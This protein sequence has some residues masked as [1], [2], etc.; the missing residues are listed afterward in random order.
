MEK[1]GFHPT[2]EVFQE[3]VYET[4]EDKFNK[5]FLPE[6]SW[7][8]ASSSFLLTWIHEYHALVL[9]QVAALLLVERPVDHHHF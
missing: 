1:L 7:L 4:E 2:T 9:R 6:D 8:Q 3:A 5:P